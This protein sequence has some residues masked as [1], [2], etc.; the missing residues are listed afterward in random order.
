MNTNQSVVVPA[1]QALI[2][3]NRNSD[4]SRS[5]SDSSQQSCEVDVEGSRQNQTVSVNEND[6]SM[7]ISNNV[8][9]ISSRRYAPVSDVEL[10]SLS[11]AAKD[12]LS[13]LRP[14][15]AVTVKSTIKSGS[16]RNVGL[17]PRESDSVTMTIFGLAMSLVYKGDEMK[18]GRG[19]SASELHEHFYGSL[20]TS[21]EDGLKISEKTQLDI[22]R[23]ITQQRLCPKYLCEVGIT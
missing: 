21:N 4:G 19:E 18:M 14:D 8:L 16:K 20:T 22:S 15:H 7:S 23:T 5:S 6:N 12:T 3:D 9:G 2:K 10:T 13:D 1:Q 11:R 17:S